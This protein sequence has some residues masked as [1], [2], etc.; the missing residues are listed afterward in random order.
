MLVV[1]PPAPPIL[2]PPVL[3]TAYS[4]AA[5][6]F[7]LPS[8]LT[9]KNEIGKKAGVHR[10]D[11]FR[12]PHLA[13]RAE[14]KLPASRLHDVT[15]DVETHAEEDPFV[16][17]LGEVAKRLHDVEIVQDPDQA[18]DSKAIA[19]NLGNL[20][21]FLRRRFEHGFQGEAGASTAGS[22]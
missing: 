10:P 22:L 12:E 13:E 19:Q 4:S 3:P 6:R 14:E 2:T 16:V 9:G 20:S 8:A 15:E 11:G 1:P 18:G 21:G 17:H 5:S 7:S